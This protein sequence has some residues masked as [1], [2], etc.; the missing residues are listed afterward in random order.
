M[1]SGGARHGS[2]GWFA[3]STTTRRRSS[4]VRD[5]HRRSTGEE[6][7]EIL[8]NAVR[9][10]PQKP[11]LSGLRPSIAS[12]HAEHQLAY[13]PGKDQSQDKADPASRAY[14]AHPHPRRSVSGQPGI[15]SIAAGY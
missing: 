5:K 1:I 4:N 3:T 9:N 10:E 6:V 11:S 14:R 8:C 13:R 2:S 7:R 12:A 15:F